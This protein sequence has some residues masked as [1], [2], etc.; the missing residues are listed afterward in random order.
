MYFHRD[1]IQIHECCIH[2]VCNIHVQ[3]WFNKYPQKIKQKTVIVEVYFSLFLSAA[4]YRMTTTGS[5]IDV[6][7]RKEPRLFR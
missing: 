6:G 5:E 2:M 7:S 1:H 4:H 3:S